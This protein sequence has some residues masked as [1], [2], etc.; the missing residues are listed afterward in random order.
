MEGASS[1]AQLV[2]LTE[3]RSLL[4][5]GQCV[6][7]CLCKLREGHTLSGEGR[8]DAR[9]ASQISR[10]NLG[11]TDVTARSPSRPQYVIW[12]LFSKA[13]GQMRHAEFEGPYW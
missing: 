13:G 12:E 7:F 4:Y 3:D 1:R 8:R 5:H 11:V 2:L 9:L 10:V 6:L